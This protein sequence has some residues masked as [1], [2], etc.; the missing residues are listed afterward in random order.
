MVKKEGVLTNVSTPVVRPST[1]LLLA[2]VMR[3]IAILYVIVSPSVLWSKPAIIWGI[4]AVSF[5]SAMA[6][7]GVFFVKTKNIM[8]PVG[9]FV[10]FFVSLVAGVL[11]QKPCD[12]DIT[13]YLGT[14]I[15]LWFMGEA[16]KSLIPRI[17]EDKRPL[18]V[19][20]Y[21]KFRKLKWLALLIIPI[22]FIL[23]YYVLILRD[24][25]W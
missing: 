10:V 12:T 20:N 24:V 5:I 21:W 9:T 11:S 1:L 23:L 17:P 3:A 8:L 7:S 22:P 16:L 18:M 25:G 13:Y 4:V 15:G 14:I 6:S 2:T 19:F